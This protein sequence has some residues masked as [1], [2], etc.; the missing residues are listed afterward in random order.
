MGPRVEDRELVRRLGGL[1][2]YSFHVRGVRARIP[3]DSVPILGRLAEAIYR[4]DNDRHD[5]PF[6]ARY[7]PDRHAAAVSAMHLADAKLTHELTQTRLLAGAIP[8]ERLP[9]ALAA[10]DFES[11]TATGLLGC[12][13]DQRIAPP[14]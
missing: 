10:G 5:V 1:L 4:V 8:D 2:L 6:A 12:L 9:T 11:F 13:T 7:H 3:R 14:Q